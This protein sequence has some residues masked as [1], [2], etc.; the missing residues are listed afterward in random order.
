[1]YYT[2]GAEEIFAPFVG[3]GIAVLLIWFVLAIATYI[4]I[5]AMYV[6]RAELFRKAELPAWKS[7]IPVYNTYNFFT[8]SWS[9]TPFYYY[10]GGIILICLSIIPA[11]L[12]TASLAGFMFAIGYLIALI[13]NIILMV[14]ISFAYGKG[15]G[16][17]VGLIFLPHIFMVILGFG[18]SEYALGEKAENEN[19]L[20]ISTEDGEVETSEE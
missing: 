18:K 11:I 6:A 13:L 5:V 20:V 2:S 12:G 3:L 4:L 17:A 15:G 9:K 10:L 14:K 1:M 19:I 8:L 16:F 7:V